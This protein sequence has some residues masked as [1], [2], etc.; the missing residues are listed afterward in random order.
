MCVCAHSLRET[1]ARV[2]RNFGVLRRCRRTLS[3]GF[4]MAGDATV[5]LEKRDE[6]GVA[7]R[8]LV[9]LLAVLCWWGVIDAWGR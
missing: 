8:D 6:T 9:A 1:C 3:R 5:R 4:K 7:A 2:V